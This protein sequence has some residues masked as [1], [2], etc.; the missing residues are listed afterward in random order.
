MFSLLIT[1]SFGAGSSLEKRSRIE[2]RGGIWPHG[3][4]TAV[5][6]SGAET[7]TKTG[8]Y[9]GG[10]AYNYW[11]QE[12][13][14]MTISLLGMVGDLETKT[15]V[16]EVSTHTVTIAPILMGVR[17]YLPRS[18]FETSMRPFLAAGVGPYI[19]S[20]TKSEVNLTVLVEQNTVTAFGGFLGG[21]MD[22]IL[23]RHFT[24]GINT[25]Y[26]FMTDFTEPL[27]G[28]DNYS[29][30]EFSFGFGYVFGGR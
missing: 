1:S 15:A 11:L 22:F 16:S 12:D 17:Y 14:A 28:R 3:S 4:K 24:L 6:V 18:S 21:G 10:L 5:R 27:G 9:M 25:G 26:H 2:L 30:P 29:G 20:E 13:L 19:G 8:G 7:T 23:S